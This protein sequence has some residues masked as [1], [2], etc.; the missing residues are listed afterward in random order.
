MK[1]FLRTGLIALI[2][3][4]PIA[5]SNTRVIASLCGY[6]LDLVGLAEV[7]NLV[8]LT[9]DDTSDTLVATRVDGLG[10]FHEF[11][12]IDPDS[13]AVGTF[14]ASAGGG[15]S[16]KLT[17]I[18]TSACQA[19]FMPGDVYAG[20]A[21][22]GQIARIS[23]TGATRTAPWVVLP[24][25]LGEIS[26][27][28]QDSHCALGGD[29]F[30]VARGLVSSNVWRIT[31]DGDATLLVTI[32]RRLEGI[33]VVP[34]NPLA[35]GPLSRH[36]V[37]GDEDR[38]LLGG[39]GS[40]GRLFA[41]DGTGASVFIVGPALSGYPNYPVTNPV[42]PSAT[43]FNPHDIDIV[44]SPRP[45]MPDDPMFFGIDAGSGR[46][47]TA[48]VTTGIHNLN[49]CNY[50]GPL[51]LTQEIPQEGW[52]YPDHA[53]TFVNG[54]F[55]LGWDG[56]KFELV[57]VEID[58]DGGFDVPTQWGDVTFRGGQDC[59]L[60]T[61]AI[62]NYVWKDLD[63]DGIQDANEPGIAGVTVTLTEPAAPGYR[64]TTV[65]DADGKYEF[66]GLCSGTYVVTI[67]PPDD[68]T[69]TVVGAGSDPAVDSNA[70][71]SEVTLTA[72]D[73]SDL[74][75]DF[76]LKGP[77]RIGDFVWHD[78]NAD[79]IQ[80][81]GEPG[82]AGVTVHLKAG[83]GNSSGP[84]LLTA[85]TNGAGLYEFI[86]LNPGDYTVLVDPPA[87]Y[88]PSPTN[89]G[90]PASD[91]NPN[92][93]NVTLT[94]SAPVDLTV[95]FGYFL[96][97]TFGRIIVNKVTD[98]ASDTTTVFTFTTTGT[99]Y[100]GFTL[101][102]GASNN[103]GDLT[104]GVY[105]VSEQLPSGWTLASAVCSNGD[106]PAEINLESEET[107]ICTFTNTKKA[108]L[109]N[110]VW[111]DTDNDGQQDGTESGVAGVTVQLYQ[112]ITLVG[113]T[114]TDGA[115][116]YL[117]G[118]LDPGSYTVKFTLPGGYSFTSQNTGSDVTD[119]DADTTSGITAPVTLAAGEINLTIDAGLKV[120]APPP[121][122]VP[123]ILSFAGS[124]STSGTAGNIRTFTSGSIS[125]KASAW[126]RS[127]S[128]G[129]WSTAFLGQYSHGLGVTDGSE[130]GGS[131]THTV[132]NMGGRDNY[133]LFEFNT[134]VLVDQALLDYVGAD[135]DISV[136]VGTKVDP[137]NNHLTL[138]D[139]L[140]GTLSSELN[141]T[142]S[143]DTRWANFNGAN[144]I[145]NVLVIAAMA[146]DDSPEDSF[147]LSK[148][149]IE[150]TPP[151]PPP[152]PTCVPATFTFSGSSSTT[153]SAGNIR[154]FSVSGTSVRASAF[155][156]KNSGGA[157]NTAY[158]G[159]YSPGLGVTDGSES[160]SA[161]K[162]DNGG[163]RDN[164]VLFEFSQPVLIDKA[165]L[166]YIGDDSDLQAWVGTKVDPYNNHQ[167][168]SDS[169]LSSLLG[170][171]NFGTG[172]PDTRWAD[173]NNG[174][175]MGNVLVIA[176][177]TSDTNDAFKINK[178]TIAC[179]PPPPPPAS[180]VAT[181]YTFTGSSSTSGS[182]GNIRTFTSAGTSVK[183]SAWSRTDGGTW[184]TAF[185][186]AWSAGMGVTDGSEGSGGNNSHTVD[187]YGRDNY[188]L[189]RFSAPVK[190]DRAFLDYIGD[191]GDISVWVGSI[192][193]AYNTTVNLNDT[194]LST[195]TAETNLSSVNTSRWADINSG[196]L[197]GN[198][199]VI[200]AKVG[201]T[202]DSFKLS[203]LD[204]C[205]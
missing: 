172:T 5:M 149:D 72:D 155:S 2:V 73:S 103:S 43:A 121:A 102:G 50:C 189:L 6:A 38:T 1:R 199:L 58:P 98:P 7:S 21:V 95:D 25:E 9:W 99:G 147:K 198:V 191:D 67:T 81:S 19:G 188:V 184:N 100:Q 33:A 63:E 89:V 68:D 13:G 26:G 85:V 196:G 105:S 76:G 205:K 157:W 159:L 197:V 47:L 204:S 162:V 4:L 154:T 42:L 94:S 127:D 185:L 48:D 136:W 17:A 84:D 145:G 30:V 3:M 187:N 166:T 28:Y 75:I 177:K 201:E 168:L 108:A 54:L 65:T 167:T 106:A 135:S 182:A 93:S 119:S 129:T 144:I 110:Y 193:N 128:G 79:G 35:Y 31:A 87:G 131:D 51:L 34:N 146:S 179:D 36:I 161:H 115:G 192:T 37:V 148:L 16:V 120:N 8:G 86:N 117:F 15:D 53:G 69:F 132:D 113:T 62:G 143:G 82:I 24:G 139:S 164:Y 44:P 174:A 66:T 10:L 22:P 45:G 88:T 97:P 56:A 57:A 96:P 169:F 107:V 137:F 40:E 64:Q 150:C 114:A 178:L 11:K 203:K 29:L 126:S 140:L 12:A 70:N 176:A 78:L 200:A 32:P 134:P 23:N 156:R 91:S 90:G 195:L 141:E 111:L 80:D 170:E 153:G 14:S 175:V 125:V 61:G 112:G 71:G 74:T 180:C 160:G 142:T 122:C 83:L 186:G 104:P 173:L 92:P 116:L 59:R 118:N 133:I 202:N 183:A 171:T 20:T 194:V 60:C 55:V 39:N 18:K 77:G 152:P 101:T 124:S 181:N 52:E 158:L 151:Q 130:S 123:T 46:I 41:I 165:Y 109:G 163:Y 27:L 138:S 49:G 190:V